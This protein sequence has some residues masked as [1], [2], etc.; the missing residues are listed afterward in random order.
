M[1]ED[2]LKAGTSCHFNFVSTYRRIYKYY[3]P[4]FWLIDM[5]NTFF[6]VTLRVLTSKSD[7]QNSASIQKPNTIWAGDSH[8]D[9][10]HSQRQLNDVSGTFT[11][12][13]RVLIKTCFLFLI[14]TCFRHIK[15][16]PRSLVFFYPLLSP[17]KLWEYL[18]CRK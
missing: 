4:Y 15:I 1:V 18:V 6:Q 9:A 8:L 5:V 11:E 16:K 12:N 10:V 7:H 13:W 14:F 17:L 2:I 3:F